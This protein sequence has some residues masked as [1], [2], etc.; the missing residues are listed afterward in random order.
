[1]SA[2]HEP[3]DEFAHMDATAQAALVA[4]GEVSPLELVDAAIARIERGND[5]LNA[6]I[7]TRFDRAREEAG[8]DLPEGPFRGVPFLL[9]D[10]DGFSAG[11][12]YHAGNRALADAGYIAP[13]DS[14]M[15]TRFR[16]A[17][18]VILGRT[19]TPEFGLM[20]S[21]EP[22]LRGPTRNP[23]NREH[24][25]GG[26][27]GGSA[28]S[29]AAGFVPMA[30]AGDGGGSI[31]IPAS[32]CGL[33]GLKP[34]RGRHSLGPEAGEAWGGLVARMALTR[35]VRECAAVLQAVQGAMP[36]DPY[37]APPPPQPYTE[38]P[39]VAGAPLRIGFTC[40]SSDP[41]VPTAPECVEA[42]D[43]AA[44]QLEALGHSVEEARPAIWDADDFYEANV[45]PFMT[46]YG[47]WTAAELD[48]VA[49]MIGRPLTEADVEPGTWLIAEP[50]RS[51]TAL[52]YF[53]AVEFFHRT[54]REMAGFWSAEGF[55]LLLTPVMPEPPPPLGQFHDAD[56]ALAGLARS[57]QIVPYVAPFNITGQPAISLPVHR[58]AAG[59]PI[60]IQLVAACYREDLLLRVAAQLEQSGALSAGIAPA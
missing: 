39:G 2:N 33:I 27:S 28:A 53:A 18:L 48:R 45:A 60:G 47:V 37:T 49:A 56:N 51:A 26:S 50:G 22:L 59:L 55:D 7:H 25:P 17:G 35:S 40:R 52:D 5:A 57:S 3:Q 20:P 14:Y 19:N 34:S 32:S 4:S 8:G 46:A 6:V 38:V 44:R 15:T 10:L 58:S 16:Q 54:A 43:L 1:M 31:R 11:D 24:T 42:V 30:H 23:W 36:G 9:K 29:V 12:P 21:T 41:A 13:A